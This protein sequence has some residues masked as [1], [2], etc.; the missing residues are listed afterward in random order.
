MANCFNHADKEGIYICSQCWLTFC[1]SCFNQESKACNSCTKKLSL[2]TEKQP[3]RKSVLLFTAIS[4]LITLILVAS[5]F[6]SKSKPSPTNVAKNANNNRLTKSQKNKSSQN[7]HFVIEGGSN[8]QSIKTKAEEYYQAIPLLTGLQAGDSI[9]LDKI[10]ITIFKSKEDYIK[11]TGK[12]SWSEGYADYKSKEIFLIQSEGLEISVLPHEISHLFFDSYME[13]ENS[14]V[15]WLDEGLATLVQVK[16]DEKQ[17][18]SFKEA[19]KNIR[20]NGHIALAQLS[21]FVLNQQTPEDQINKYYAQTLSVV[22]YLL[23]KDFKNWQ[24]LLKKLKAKEKFENALKQ[25]FNSDLVSLEKDWLTFI[26]QN[27]QTWE[28][29]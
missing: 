4:I 26:K 17:A 6:T 18:V 23:N 25:T 8:N 20:N 12:P 9:G 11:E 10:K 21:T 24:N 5:L 2:K 15:N 27:N 19:M 7:N 16:Y 22:H 1:S 28:K 3:V 13:Y 14:D 29:S